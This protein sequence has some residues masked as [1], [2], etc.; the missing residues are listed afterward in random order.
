MGNPKRKLKYTLEIIK[1]KDTWVGINT[2]LTNH[3]AEEFIKE[4]GF[5]EI[6]TYINIRKEVKYGKNSRIDILLESDKKKCY[7]EVKNVSMVF[8]GKASFPDA[9]SER[10]TK[11][12]LEL[13]NVVKKGDR[14][15]ML[16][17][18]QRDD[19]TFFEPAQHIDPIYAKTLLMASKAGVEI[20]VYKAK[21]SFRENK[22][23][24]KIPFYLK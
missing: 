16:F 17:I 5:S 3:L 15:I 4:N 6:G 8:D 20:L 1:I 13:I 14:G 23:Y 2:S 22:V 11:H 24:C 7:I 12:L 19:A 10:G 21:V 18:C 9:V